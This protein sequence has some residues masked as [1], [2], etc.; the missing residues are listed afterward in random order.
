MIRAAVLVAL[1][2]LSTPAFAQTADSVRIG[3]VSFSYIARN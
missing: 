1:S 3:A 2:L